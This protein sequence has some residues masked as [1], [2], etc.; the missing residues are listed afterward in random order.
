MAS[1]HL[2]SDTGEDSSPGVRSLCPCTSQLKISVYPEVR[3]PRNPWAVKK[4]ILLEDAIAANIS[5]AKKNK[6]SRLV[7]RTH[8]V[9]FAH[10]ARSDGVPVSVL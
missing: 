10:H 7:C 3:D 1:L 9:S 6:K 8:R 4:E 2:E 5:Q